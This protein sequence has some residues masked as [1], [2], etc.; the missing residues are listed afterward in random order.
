MAIKAKVSSEIHGKFPCDAESVA[1]PAVESY[2]E[3]DDRVIIPVGSQEQHGRHLPLGVD[4]MI[5][6]ALGRLVAERTRVLCVSPVCYGMSWLHSGF[7]G[8]VALKLATLSAI[9]VDIVE[10]LYAQGFRRMLILNGHGGNTNALNAALSQ[11][12]RG[13]DDL[14]VKVYQWWTIPA[15]QGICLEAFGA[16]DSHAGPAETSVMLHLFPGAVRMEAA[17]DNSSELLPHFPNPR[18]IRDVYPDGVM[19]NNAT[20]ADA[21]AGERIVAAAASFL[22]GELG[23]GGPNGTW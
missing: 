22:G 20:Q 8:T 1:W 2:L 10:E 13:M 4:W 12:V 6:Y 5:P 15:V 7:A 23:A 9:Y 18:Q 16:L 21:A 17:A 14:R 3:R 11:L 19:Q